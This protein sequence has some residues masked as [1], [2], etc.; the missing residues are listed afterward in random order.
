A[1]ALFPAGKHSQASTTIVEGVLGNSSAPATPRT[2][3]SQPTERGSGSESV[4][5]A[6]Y[7][8]ITYI[9]TLEQRQAEIDSQHEVKSTKLADAD[10]R[11]TA[12]MQEILALVKERRELE[13][14]IRRLEERNRNLEETV[15]HL[16]TYTTGDD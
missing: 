16:K 11:L 4:V 13:T 7:S 8:A 6:L 10:V 12:A 2:P 14:K 1:S 3:A 9:Q 5:A 15:E